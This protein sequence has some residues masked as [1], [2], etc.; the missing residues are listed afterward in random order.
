MPG[1]W[2]TLIDRLAA[3]AISLGVTVATRSPIDRLPDGPVVLA[4][5]TSVAVELT[6]DDTLVANGTRTAILD[7][8]LS[9]QAKPPFI[10]SDFDEAGWIE[11][12]SRADPTLAPP[13]QHLVQCQ[14]GMRPDES[15]DQ[16]VER[17]ENL[18]DAATPGWRGAEVWRRRAKLHAASGAL[19]LPGNGWN[20]R[21]QV[22]RAAGVYVVNDSCAQ[23]G[24]L[25]EVS[26][27]AGIAAITAL[28][29]DL[30]TPLLR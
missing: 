8:G 26:F 21:P 6:G 25:A 1:G 24:L 20:D 30:R 5:P 14:K 27:N 15:L 10:V 28:D 19:D 22:R 4:V 7:L 2:S 9:D 17:I 16:A 18:L 13:G 12:F 29:A 11:T 3:H 23:P